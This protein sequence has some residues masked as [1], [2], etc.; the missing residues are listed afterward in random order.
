[1]ISVDVN[2]LDYLLDSERTG[3]FSAYGCQYNRDYVL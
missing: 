3:D 2:I 1:M